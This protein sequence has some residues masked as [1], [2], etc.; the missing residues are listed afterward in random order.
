M[1]DKYFFHDLKHVNVVANGVLSLE[2][3]NFNI[4]LHVQ[5]DIGRGI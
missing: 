1:V 5:S 3:D 2:G 4:T